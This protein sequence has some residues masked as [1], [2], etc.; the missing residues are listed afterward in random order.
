MQ[1]AERHWLRVSEFSEAY[2]ISRKHCYELLTKGLVPATKRKGF[3]WLINRRL[4]E[5]ELEASIE[6]RSAQ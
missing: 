2:G 1:I 5:K 3:G 4:F 6:M